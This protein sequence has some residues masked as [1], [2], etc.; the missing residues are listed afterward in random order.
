M[1]FPISSG[2]RLLGMESFGKILQPRAMNVGIINL[3][4][5][6]AITLRV[7]VA[8]LAQTREISL[9]RYVIPDIHMHLLATM[10]SLHFVE[11][12][13]HGEATTKTH[14]DLDTR[15]LVAPKTPSS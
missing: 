7:K 6:G 9:A 3:A 1:E 14:F 8:A 5:T 10:L 11:H 12:T 4:Q 2:K 13:P 15:H